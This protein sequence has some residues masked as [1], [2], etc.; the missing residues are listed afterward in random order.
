LRTGPYGAGLLPFKKGLDLGR[1]EED[2]HG[3]DLG[4]LEPC[5]PQRLQT[6]SRRIELA[7]ELFLGDLG[8]LRR[9]LDAET[10]PL[11]LIGRRQVRSN[12]SW[13]HNYERLMRGK[14]RCT[15]LLHP[16]DARRIGVEDGAEVVVRSRV[17]SVRVTAEV[18]DAIRPGVVSLPHGWGHDRSRTL[19]SI[20]RRHPGASVN[21]LTD[22]L[23]VDELSGNAALN[24]VPVTITL[25]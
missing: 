25:E 24:G 15:L 3:L 18:T 2:P 6:P 21:D 16:E 4:P 12:N 19:Q 8:R 13:M 20:A 23:L 22:H 9:L 5:L 7:P 11:V 10:P 1:L 14:E 17:A